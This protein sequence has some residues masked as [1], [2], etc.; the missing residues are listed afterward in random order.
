MAMSGNGV[1]RPDESGSTLVLVVG[2]GLAP[3]EDSSIQNKK[4]VFLFML[5]SSLRQHAI[6][7]KAAWQ[8]MAPLD[9][10]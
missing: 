5:K 7:D 9:N 4:N 10:F 3:A 2:Q 1:E 6:D 8:V